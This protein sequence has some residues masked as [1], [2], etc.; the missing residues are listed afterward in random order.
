MSGILEKMKSNLGLTLDAIVAVVA[1][2][3]IAWVVFFSVPGVRQEIKQT[4]GDIR[5][6][7]Q[8]RNASVVVPS[9]EMVG[10]CR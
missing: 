9:D 2:C 7:S 6:I 4:E 5:Q 10:G 8:Y 1:L 3:V